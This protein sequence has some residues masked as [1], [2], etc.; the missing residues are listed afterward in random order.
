MAF[1]ATLNTIQGT[2]NYCAAFILNRPSVNVA[3]TYQEPAIT[4]ANLI[5][6]TVLAPPFKW[7]WNRNF[8]NIPLTVG[9]SD[10][11][12]PLS[13]FGWLEEATISFSSLN[14]PVVE[15]QIKPM[16]AADGVQAQPF[17]ISVVNDDNAGNITFRFMAIPDNTYTATL[18][19]QKAPVKVTSLFGSIEAVIS[20]ISAASNGSTVYTCSS[21]IPG[22]LSLIG[23]YVNIS[24][25]TDNRNNGLF[26][27]LAATNTTLTLQNPN[28]VVQ[29]GAG[30]TVASATTWAP[31][32]DKFNFLYER[33]MLAQLHG[34][35]DAATYL[36]E[37]EI[38]FRQLVGCA[39]G[40][41]DTAKA[42]FLED[43]LAQ[44]RTQAATQNA[45][46]ATP[47]R[48]Q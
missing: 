4:I 42:I 33:A 16:M 3:N 35:Y 10:Y 11:T 25:A 40:L 19:Y 29:S 41:D 47:K 34:I 38:F 32:P 45:T 30:G 39:E 46:T 18:I 17:Q 12:V 13:D 22:F 8:V 20:S 28:G 2:L 1:N 9:Q 27:V 37:L 21:G 26:Y 15:L 23:T 7:Q 44:L 43:R 14:P 6:S 24:G 48:A 5:L 31:I 36:Q